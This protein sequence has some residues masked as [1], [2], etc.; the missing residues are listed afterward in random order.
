MTI[1]RRNLLAGVGV[2]AAASSATATAAAVTPG[3]SRAWASGAGKYGQSLERLRQYVEQHRRAY[4]LPGLTLVVVD[5]QGYVG[6]VTSGYADLDSRTP[7]RSNHVFQIGSISKSMVGLAVYRMVQAGKL[8]LETDVRDI[9]KGV[10][11]ETIE[12]GAK[13]SLLRLLDHSS[14]LPDD[15]PLFPRAT[16]DVLWTGFKPGTHWSYCN[17]GYD[18]LGK[19]L[20]TVTG[21]SFE[22]VC[23]DEVL[24]PLGMTNAEGAIRTQDR[25]RYATGYWPYQR[26]RP[27]LPGA[28]LDEAPW[29]DVTFAAGCVA[30]SSEEMA[31]YMR[32]LIQAG[33]GKGSPLLN[34]S[35]AKAYT[36][37]TVDAPGWGMKDARYG[38]GWATV[39]IGGRRMLHHTGGMVAFSSSV[40]IDPEAGIACFASTNVGGLNYRPRN[41]TS[42]ACQLFRAARDGGKAPEPAPTESKIDDPVK[43]VGRFQAADGDVIEFKAGGP[44]GL[45]VADRT[46]GAGALEPVGE[47]AYVARHPRFA[48]HLLFVEKKGGR[49][50]AVWY[51]DKE[52]AAD[53]AKLRGPASP[54][55]RALAG[56]YD[57]D[58]PWTG[59]FRVV[60]RPTGLFLDGVTKMT[61]LE[62]GAWR[63]GDEDWNPE[64]I[65]FD[66]E[67][68]GRPTRLSYSGLDFLRRD[69][70]I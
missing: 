23:K 52:Y 57:N 10:E 26:D 13:V 11:I 6:Y 39:K 49:T 36:T 59:V 69:D 61:R 64:R 50:V 22:Q 56:R 3:P 16:G 42:W 34:D 24:R 19:V 2:A 32:W 28:R 21:K 25:D 9:L 54:D 18:M 55:L 43:S 14:G 40:H 35:L 60:A 58:D 17:T 30:A 7:V 4:G 68:N 45:Q 47:D 27:A 38:G 31:K 20:E 15:P 46:G 33:R 41:I 48:V 62:T 67:V 44:T 1:H 5:D 51:G 53:P 63:F 29:L 8:D 12:P 70:R 66:A 37:P 65:W